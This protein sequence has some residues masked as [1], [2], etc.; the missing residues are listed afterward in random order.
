LHRGSRLSRENVLIR[1]KVKVGII[2][3]LEEIFWMWPGEIFGCGWV[4][5][6]L[7]VISRYFWFTKFFHAILLPHQQ[8]NLN[9]RNIKSERN[10]NGGLISM[11]N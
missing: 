10:I 4:H 8:Y 7:L 1:G 5:E 2:G 3:D 9:V 11:T 6:I